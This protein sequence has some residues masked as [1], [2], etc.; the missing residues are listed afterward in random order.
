VDTSS[1]ATEDATVALFDCLGSW[2]TGAPA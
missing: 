1:V 2:L